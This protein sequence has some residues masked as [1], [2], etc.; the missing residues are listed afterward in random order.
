MQTKTY[1]TIGGIVII[2][3]GL[4]ALLSFSNITI[5]GWSPWLVWGLLVPALSGLVI[6]Y[7]RWQE[8]GRQLDFKLFKQNFWLLSPLVIAIFFLFR[9]NWAYLGAIFFI[10]VGVALLLGQRNQKEQ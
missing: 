9:L 7:Q 4:A 10:G 8:N 1:Q 6:G 2:T 5:L 3:L